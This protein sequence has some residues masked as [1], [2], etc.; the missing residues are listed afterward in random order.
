MT[1]QSR[2]FCFEA[3]TLLCLAGVGCNGRSASDVA[4]IDD[5]AAEYVLAAAPEGARGVLETKETLQESQA[6]NDVVVEVRI[7]GLDDQVFDP[8][9]AAFM[10]A[11][12][13]I[14]LSVSEQ[15]HDDENCPFCQKKKQDL[16]AGIALVQ[17]V[18]EQGRVV[19]VPA[20]KLLGLVA[21]QTVILTGKG[22]IDGLGNLVVDATGVFA[23]PTM[24][25]PASPGESG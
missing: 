8:D 22:K 5:L 20:D 19:P 2:T 7:G 21:G 6:A 9:R 25:Q 16:M 4:G 15:G 12:M 24:E 11:D 1:N 3:I 14:D 18:D 10:I 17:L 13:S 23:N